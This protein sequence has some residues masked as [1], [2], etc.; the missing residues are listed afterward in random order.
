MQGARAVRIRVGAT[1]PNPRSTVPSETA[2]VLGFK[3]CFFFRD[4]Y[5]G[6]PNSY[7]VSPLLLRVRRGRQCFRGRPLDPT[8]RDRPSIYEGP[9]QAGQAYATFGRGPFG[10]GRRL[11]PPGLPQVPSLTSCAAGDIDLRA[12]F[13]TVPQRTSTI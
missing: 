2:H 5:T 4:S 11:P 7:T 9:S 6:G 8:F 1:K 10:P 3:Q 12:N 13:S